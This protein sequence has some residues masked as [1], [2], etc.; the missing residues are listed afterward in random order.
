MPNVTFIQDLIQEQINL[1]KN[2]IN[3]KFLSSLFSILSEQEQVP[4]TPN[5]PAA[6][7]QDNKEDT[8]TSLPS[9]NTYTEIVLSQLAALSL[10]TDIEKVLKDHPHTRPDIIKLSQYK[11]DGISGKSDILNALMKII[12]IVKAGGNTVPFEIDSEF[13]KH[14]DAS[15]NDA[16]CNLILKALFINKEKILQNNDSLRPVL[17][18]IG[19]LQSQIEPIKNADPIAAVKMAKEIVQK[20]NNDIFP[21]A[22]L[23]I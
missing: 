18:S 16:S 1:S 3:S 20:I 23:T 15:A 22:D 10:L 5:I 9:E 11:E 21:S 12:K 8:E 14:F 17:D 19:T 2:K 6:P 13:V 4:E 7:V